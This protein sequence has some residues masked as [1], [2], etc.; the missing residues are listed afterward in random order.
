[1]NLPDRTEL[2]AEMAVQ[3]L[4]LLNSFTVLGPWEQDGYNMV[5]RY[6]GDGKIAICV[7]LQQ[8]GRY[9]CCGHSMVVMLHALRDRTFSTCQEIQAAVDAILAQRD[10]VRAVG[11]ERKL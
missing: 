1:M 2:T 5:R 7:F 8:P 3:M 4:E 10:D 9:V 11:I 6:A